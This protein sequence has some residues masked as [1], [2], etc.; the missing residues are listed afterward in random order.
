MALTKPAGVLL[1]VVG[2]VFIFNGFPLTFGGSV[3]GW[4][5]VALGVLVLWVGGKPA[6]KTG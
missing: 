3:V 5:F 2:A 1:Q 4:V 6:R